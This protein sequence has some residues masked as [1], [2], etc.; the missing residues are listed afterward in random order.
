MIYDG[1]IKGIGVNLRPV[2]ETDAEFTYWLRQDKERTKYVHSVN[3]TVEDQKE[4]I[5]KQRVREGDYFFIV[6]DK[7]G[8]PL[9]TVG[10]YDIVHN[11][12]E[13]GR[14]V[15]NG[16]FSQNCDAI[17]QLRRFA[18][19]II[20]ADYVRCTAVS[21]NKPVVA[22]LKRLGGIQT[23]QYT[24][25]K[26]GFDILVFRVTKEAYEAK[27]DYYKKLVEKSYQLNIE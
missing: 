21:T 5:K 17:I 3:G 19:E 12:G 26:D 1:I 22:Q 11:N 4:W 14:M 15:I 16:N 24:D 18:F 20:G 27:K 7:Q 10:Y 8:T 9:G 2:E 25:P 13:M 23:D 6:E